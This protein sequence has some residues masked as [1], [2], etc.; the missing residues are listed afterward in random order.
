MRI[1]I[2]NWGTLSSSPKY[3]DDMGL[4]YISISSNYYNVI[5]KKLFFLSVIE[6]GIVY[7]E[8]K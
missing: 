6:H 1:K 4:R 5:D 8:T 7:K 2:S 3:L